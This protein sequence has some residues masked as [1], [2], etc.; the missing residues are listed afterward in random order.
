MKKKPIKLNSLQ[1]LGK[2]IS[3]K[4]IDERAYEGN[5]KGRHYIDEL[6]QWNQV[7]KKKNENNHQ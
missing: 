6:T 5:P 1:D 3:F 7:I 2:V 4:P